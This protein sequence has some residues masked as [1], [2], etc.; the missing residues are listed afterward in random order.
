MKN[1]TNSNE[2]FNDDL[3]F[4]KMGEDTISEYMVLKGYK[5]KRID[6]DYETLSKGDI[7]VNKGYIKKKIEVKSDAWEYYK[8]KKTGNIAIEVGKIDK[9]GKQ[10]P[11]GLN[12]TD[13]DYFIYFFPVESIAYI[14]KVKELRRL[15]NMGRREMGGDRKASVLYLIKRDELPDFVKTISIPDDINI[16]KTYISGLPI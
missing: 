13:A 5:T 1:K 15:L 9:C 2:K 6:G 14:F 11:S 4:G 12:I 7:I 16:I 8:G 3:K 10:Q